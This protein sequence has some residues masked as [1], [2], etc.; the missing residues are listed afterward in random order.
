MRS[1][2]SF[3]FCCLCTWRTVQAFRFMHTVTGAVDVDDYRM[4]NHAI[5]HGGRDYRITKIFTPN[6][7]IDIGC[8]DGG[9]L[10][11]TALNDLK[12]KRSISA[13]FLLQP[14]KS[15]FIDQGLQGPLSAFGQYRSG[16]QR[17]NLP[18]AYARATWIV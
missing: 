17:Q 11:V 2:G 3:A 16:T 15:D 13:R 12:K 18:E 5:D 14:I 7:K 4:M 1:G 10:A 6:R 9:L 8:Q